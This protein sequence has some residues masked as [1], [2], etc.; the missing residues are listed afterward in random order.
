[1]KM[2][3]FKDGDEM[4]AL[5]LGTWKAGP[6]EVGDAI[7]TAVEVGYRHVDCAAIYGNEAE[8]GAAL[9][10]AGVARGE[11]WITSK[12]WNDSH[13]P[14]HVRPALEKTLTDLRL[15]FLDLY[16]VHWPV[17]LKNG[18]LIP[19]SADDFESLDD[20]PLAETWA[21]MEDVAEAGLC[22]HI[23]VSNFSVKKVGALLDG[24][25]RPPEV[26]QVELHPYLQQPDLVGFCRERGV[27]VT[28][29]SPLGSPDRPDELKASDE[30]VLLDDPVIARIAERR[31]A[32]PAQVLL[33]WALERG[34]AVIPKSVNRTRQAENLEAAELKLHDGDV[35]EIDALDRGR[36]YVSGDIWTPEGSPYTLANLWDE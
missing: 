4:P 35:S 18:T 21:A 10:D 32:T 31:D 20:V 12:L 9:A 3:R 30:P 1:M 26:N 33:A 23:G 34:T 13:R 2:L 36:R 15:D 11:L 22:K 24:V 8:V 19:E 25:R 14:E 28:G 17:A 6:G 16:L 29:Y 27:H 5:G 7:R